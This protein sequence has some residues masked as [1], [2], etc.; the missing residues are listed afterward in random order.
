VNRTR[1][2]NVLML[3]QNA[4]VPLDRRVW[5]E[6][7]TLTAAGY[8]VSV[9]CAAGTDFHAEPY[10]RLEGIDVFRYPLEPASSPVLGYAREYGQSLWRIRG[11]VRRLARDRQFDVVHAANPPDVLLLAALDLKLRG[12]CFVFDHHDLVP[13]LIEARF[14]GRGG[15][16]LRPVAVSVERLAFRL[17][18]VVLATNESYRRIAVERGRKLPEDVFVV[19]NGPDLSR[20]RP[21]PPDPALRKGR[22]HLVAYLGVMGEQDGI[23]HAV[24]ALAALHRRRR[25]WR[26]LFVG[27]GE[28]LEPMTRLVAE[29]GLEDC[30]EFTGWRFDDDIR[31]I[32][33]TADVC[34]APDPPTRLNDSS[35]MVKIAEY[36][37]MGCAVASYDLT[38][39]RFSAGDAAL[40]ARPGDPLDLA[41]C[42]DELL[43]DAERRCEMVEFGR[44]RVAEQ[45]AWEHSVTPLLAAYERALAQGRPREDAPEVPAPQPA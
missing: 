24:Q 11:L 12:A 36:M 2:R 31:R 40:Y 1:D 6:A 39:S 8:A 15:R 44:R 42:L 41:R 33:S 21:V 43:S 25:D 22:P 34:I 29:L 38:E 9:V 17:A 4:P 5:N 13:E 45:L 16:A 10:E 23:D 18:D 28:M 37:A 32:L 7:R 27:E 26:A 3:S 14:A 30:I 19:R 20:F 35:T